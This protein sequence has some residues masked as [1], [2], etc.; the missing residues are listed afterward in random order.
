MPD[1]SFAAPALPL[2]PLAAGLLTM[3]A[4][5]SLAPLAARANDAA[6]QAASDAFGT[7][8]GRETIGLYTS[9]SVRGFSPTAAGNVRIDGLY[10]D[11]VWGLSARLRQS[12]N[13]RVGLSAQGF[14]F[15]APTGIVDLSLRRPDAEPSAQLVLGLDQ[16]RGRY[17][18]LDFSHPLSTDG[19]WAVTGGFSKAH[20]EY[21]NGTDGEFTTGSLALWWRP[22]VHT[23]AMVFASAID[24]PYDRMGPQVS[25]ATPSLPPL[26]EARVFKGPD[27]AAYSG[28]GRNYGATL[29]H[30]F[31]PAWQLRA[32]I[33]H[34]ENDDRASFSNLLLGMDAQGQAQRLVIADPAS[35][36]ASNSGELRLSWAFAPAPWA[37]RLH[38]QLA[39]RARDRRTGG[40]QSLDYGTMSQLQPF[41]PPQPTFAFGAQSL[42]EVKQ[43][44]LGL[45]YE[46]R[47]NQQLEFNAGL[48]HSDYRKRVDRPGLPLTETQATPWLYNLS[49]A[50]H[51]SP[52]LAAYAGLTRG[53]EES[54]VAPGNASNRNQALPAI[55]TTQMDAG[56]RWQMS[57]RLKLVAGVFDVRKPY[58]N[59][60]AQQL[61]TELGDVRHRGLELSLNGRP[62]PEWQLVAGAVLMQP[63]VRGEG[64]ALGRV[65]PR[66]V[67][68]A[69][70]ILKLNAVYRPA[71]LG[72]LSFDA[73]FSHTGRM[74]ATRDNRVELPALSELDL[75]LRWPLQ[76]AGQPST[77]RFLLSNA[78]NRRSLE[79]RGSGSYAE[80]QGRLLAVNLSSRW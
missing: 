75:G 56:L 10:F 12:S 74:P 52:E 4:A 29:R 20:V 9:G 61:F 32:G 64:V 11:Q 14:V 13:V 37:Q 24:T 54:G 70:R 38:L 19:R 43:R 22:D 8:I 40:S 55:L 57:P 53:L 80:R 17:I 77:L 51:F 76:L 5:L 62:A 2:T 33:F 65:G 23:E 26:G 7:S 63:R 36:V 25:S 42:D 6:V 1:R 28:V 45:S 47:W 69:E 79:L 71:A 31:D 16:W 60:D 58:Y 34:S 3:M 30:A 27:W 35:R 50:W 59:L 67:G 66:P 48:Q 18:D 39:G 78:L 44:W 41:Q 68:Q 73:G 46:L 49:A 21:G 72:G 15:P